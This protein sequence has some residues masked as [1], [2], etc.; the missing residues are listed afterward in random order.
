MDTSNLPSNL[1]VLQVVIEAIAGKPFC[2]DAV[3]LLVIFGKY[4]AKT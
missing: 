1:S 3:Q 4:F 2:D